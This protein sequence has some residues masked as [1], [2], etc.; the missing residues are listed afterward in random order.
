MKPPSG[1]GPPGIQ[2]QREFEGNRLAKDNQARA[3]QKLLP[4]G[5]GSETRT[6]VMNGSSRH[7]EESLVS[8]EG[9]AA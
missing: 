7:M 4:I 8:Q 2:T 3:Y 9:V 6:S 5:R 1:S